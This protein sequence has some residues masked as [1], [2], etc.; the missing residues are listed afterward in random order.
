MVAHDNDPQR[1]VHVTAERVRRI[2]GEGSFAQRANGLWVGTVDL[3]W[4]GGRRVRKSVSAK[5]K[6]EAQR[7]FVDLKRDAAKG[8]IKAGSAMTVE[9][10]LN[11]WLDT[12]ASERIRART[13][14]GY[15]SYANVWLI[16]YLGAHPLSKLTEDH[17]RSLYRAMK[18][19]GK[20]D[21]TRR[22]AHAI[23]RRALVVAQREG[24]VNR[25]VAAN[26]DSP[27]VGV[28]HRKPLTLE[29]ARKVLNSLDGDPLAARWIAALLLGMRQGEC[30][31]LR[32]QDV[33]LEAVVI[34]VRHEI[35]R[36]T[37]L[38]LV[39]CPP[40]SKTSV[41][42]LPILGPMAYALKH[43]EHR[44]DYVFYGH[45]KEPRLDYQAWKHLLVRAG[46]CEPGTKLGDMPELAS[47]RT[48]TSTLLRDVGVADTVNR[49]VLGHSTVTVNQNSYQRTDAVTIR[50][51][52]VALGDSVGQVVAESKP[53]RLEVINQD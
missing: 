6:K 38:G 35:L 18:D 53:V 47:A 16:P 2:R 12:I 13:L 26:V 50:A 23:L 11:H 34:H 46:V 30:L 41:R 4:R 24:R 31:G 22:Q 28:N 29:Q 48:T 5:T 49:D 40:K 45:A 9:A 3:G 15:R 20:S 51:A 43:T 42:E 52:L 25:N 33:D 8:V 14:Q 32:W 27:P 7:K 21:A 19:N 17:V 36:I 44:G 37:G 39:L 1:G 10:W